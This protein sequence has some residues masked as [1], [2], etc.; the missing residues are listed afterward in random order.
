VDRINHRC[1]AGQVDHSIRSLPRR[2]GVLQSAQDARTLPLIKMTTLADSRWR[3][4]VLAA[5]VVLAIIAGVIG[6]LKPSSSV[7]LT[8]LNS[9]D[10]LQARFNQDK[11]APRLVLLLS[12]T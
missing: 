6:A 12:P 8:D 9:I 10:E 1:I 3:W 11:G 5:V 7:T 4:L 2:V